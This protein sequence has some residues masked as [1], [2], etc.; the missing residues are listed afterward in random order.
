[1]LSSLV[2]GS[3]A[4]SLKTKS[5]K[6]AA[7]WALIPGAGQ[8]YNG[9]YIKAGIIL[10][11]E[12]AAVWRFS[13]NRQAYNNYDENSTGSKSRYME[14]RNKYGW[15]IFFTYVYGMLDAV[16]DAHLAPFD[17]VMQEDLESPEI[18]PQPTEDTL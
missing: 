2:L 15:W 9:K 18:T 10:S 14:K 3:S 11:A 7:L 4:D 16:V 5:P 17:E 12:I 6:K 8:A 13:E 1:M